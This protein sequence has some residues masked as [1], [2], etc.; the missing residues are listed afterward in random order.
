MPDCVT[1]PPLLFG[2]C[3][4]IFLTML[5]P[6]ARLP[7]VY[8]RAKVGLDV[9]SL[10]DTNKCR[11]DLQSW[12]NELAGA[13]SRTWCLL[14]LSWEVINQ[15]YI[16]VKQVFTFSGS[17]WPIKASKENGGFTLKEKKEVSLQTNE[18][19]EKLCRLGTYPSFAAHQK[20][21]PLYSHISL[22]VSILRL[23]PADF[24][25]CQVPQSVRAVKYK[26]KMTSWSRGF[27]R[28]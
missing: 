9:S 12:E 18:Q 22:F 26:T 11:S 16:E 19:L 28:V 6:L 23:T 3:L 2:N 21:G 25:S 8:S 1:R 13:Y 7:K 17:Y 24:C 27:L 10:V 5:C 15:T 20:H 14:R 4:Q